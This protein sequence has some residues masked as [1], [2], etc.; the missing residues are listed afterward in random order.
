MEFGVNGF[1]LFGFGPGQ[2]LW[3]DILVEILVVA[4][5][6]DALIA[7]AI[8][9]YGLH[10]QPSIGTGG[11]FQIAGERTDVRNQPVA[12]FEGHAWAGHPFAGEHSGPNT[13]A[14][15]LGT[16]RALPHRLRSDMADVHGH[17]RNKSK[18]ECVSELILI[19]SHELSASHSDADAMV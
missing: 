4:F 14:N 3:G 11:Q 19:E 12:S 17:M 8:A 7:A 13:V 10:G 2:D 16:M 15:L 6:G 9:V 5:G 18:R 1:D